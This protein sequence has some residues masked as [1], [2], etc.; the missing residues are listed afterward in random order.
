MTSARYVQIRLRGGS[1]TYS[2]DWG[3]R[4]V[5][6][7]KAATSISTNNT[8]FSFG[9]SIGNISYKPPVNANIRVA[10]Y[11][12]A[13]SLLGVLTMRNATRQRPLL[14]QSLT[15][16]PLS[17]YSNDAWSAT[18]P[19]N[20][21]REGTLILIGTSYP[22]ETSLAL[23]VLRLNNLAAWS[24]HTL[25]RTKVVIF[26]NATDIASLETSTHD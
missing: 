19:W 11:T 1:S 16:M 26:G 14:E 4:Q 17:P 23:N 18:L 21:M 12:N 15:T 5:K 9:T 6:I 25:S 20:W 13:G 24:H 2:S 3:L 8:E 22:N 7:S 10:A